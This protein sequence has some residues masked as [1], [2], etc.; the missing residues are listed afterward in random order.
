MLGGAAVGSSL[1][2]LAFANN[3]PHPHHGS[4]S[5]LDQD[6]Y[7]Q[8]CEVHLRLDTSGGLETAVSEPTNNQAVLSNRVSLG[9]C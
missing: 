2:R 7:T 8:N 1:T 3:H 9:A 6:T 4:L 5:H